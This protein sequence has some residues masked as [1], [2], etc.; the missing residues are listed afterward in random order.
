MVRAWPHVWA[1]DK[2]ADRTLNELKKEPAFKK[3]VAGGQP[4]TYQLAG[5]KMKGRVGYFRLRCHLQTAGLARNWLGPLCLAGI[6]RINSN[7]A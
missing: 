5:A 2:A 6:L 4:V 7:P 1:N 3:L